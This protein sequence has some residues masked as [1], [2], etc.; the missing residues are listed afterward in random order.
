MSDIGDF[1]ANAKLDGE[2]LARIIET[3]GVGAIPIETVKKI[4]DR[5][6]NFNDKK[7]DG[8]RDELARKFVAGLKVEQ[9][10]AMAEVKGDGIIFLLVSKKI[11]ALRAQFIEPEVFGRLKPET[12]NLF[13]V[14]QIESLTAEQIGAMS[15]GQISDL[16]GFSEALVLNNKLQHLPRALLGK[17][18]VPSV[19]RA[20]S[21]GG[22]RKEA[23]A[24][25]LI[26]LAAVGNI[27]FLSPELIS[28]LD[29]STMEELGK[30]G[31]KT[32]YGQLT[33]DQ[34]DALAN[35]REDSFLWRGD[36]K[37]TSIENPN[38]LSAETLGKVDAATLASLSN[39]QFAIFDEEHLRVITLDQAR[40]LREDQIAA[41]SRANKLQ[42]LDSAVLEVLS[43]DSKIK[44][45]PEIQLKSL[46][47][48]DKLRMIPEAVANNRVRLFNEINDPK[49]L[50]AIAKTE[51]SH[52]GEDSLITTGPRE[53]K[54]A[55]T[56]LSEYLE[57]NW[58]TPIARDP[59]GVEAHIEGKL[60][61]MVVRNEDLSSD[62]IVNGLEFAQESEGSEKGLLD[63]LKKQIEASPEDVYGL[64]DKINMLRAKIVFEDDR[65]AKNDYLVF[66]ETVESLLQEAKNCDSV[67]K[68][69]SAMGTLLSLLGDESLDLGYRD[70]LS[71]R[72]VGLA[73][74]FKMFC[75][76]ARPNIGDMHQFAKEEL[77]KVYLSRAKMI[78]EVQSI[79]A[80]KIDRLLKGSMKIE[81]PGGMTIVDESALRSNL[82]T[83]TI[84]ETIYLK[85]ILSAMEINPEGVK[86]ISTLRFYFRKGIEII[87]T[88]ALTQSLAG[89]V[90]AS[91]GSTVAA[92]VSAGG[93]TLATN[94]YLNAAKLDEYMQ[95]SEA[96]RKALHLSEREQSREVER[97][98]FRRLVRGVKKLFNKFFGFLW[99]KGKESKETGS[100][101]SAYRLLRSEENVKVAVKRIR[102]YN[103]LS[104]RE[105][106][107]AKEDN[108]YLSTLG[109]FNGIAL[110]GSKND[111]KGSQGA[112]IGKLI[113]DLRSLKNEAVRQWLSKQII[114][115]KS[116][117]PQLE[118]NVNLEREKQASTPL[119]TT[120]YGIISTITRGSGQKI[121]PEKMR[122]VEKSLRAR[123]ISI[124]KL[125]S[126]EKEEF[127]EMVKKIQQEA[128]AYSLRVEERAAA[129]L[130]RAMGDE[131]LVKDVAEAKETH[132]KAHKKIKDSAAKFMPATSF[133]E[134]TVGTRKSINILP[135][136][137]PGKGTE[138]PDSPEPA[139]E[140]V[141]PADEAKNP[142]RHT[143]LSN[144]SQAND[145]LFDSLREG[146]ET[147]IP[148]L[149]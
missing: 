123:D 89:I 93:V 135:P 88:L 2:W 122:L 51:F 3:N 131:K 66:M 148:T 99:R 74:E 71:E 61:D 134:P 32:F 125:S 6:F 65:N 130:S 141:A 14:E 142:D 144:L 68:Y 84:G 1:P 67:D 87:T 146:T 95:A 103:V 69:V 91:V 30:D 119:V 109:M 124:E 16:I 94:K 7:Y 118:I 113:D 58:K 50:V 54:N 33:P 126:E 38:V 132:E 73:E 70:I 116:K 145:A 140:V 75:Y 37:I 17:L 34:L 77:C 29:D 112:R 143:L 49:L 147:E 115:L 55:G 104:S 5:V 64:G 110:S 20:A 24:N 59:A 139:R 44:V 72:L 63:S 100:S 57:G 105:Y 31:R 138:H 107:G 41:L 137:L 81:Q 127:L 106:L 11:C 80:D 8:A 90:R 18:D 128:T 85:N 117:F 136:P 25:Q 27:G 60:S 43:K 12:L 149:R 96:A 62:V 108:A 15:E 52:G 133:S 120:A 26:S 40:G 35:T 92:A 4:A 98:L 114:E 42:H 111:E 9:L 46:V 97:G 23:M 82:K 76:G 102:E 56:V 53:R 19:L 101:R 129:Q 28:G 22:K 79:D 121:S 13:T 10:E 83:L 36:R 45:L 21:G 86:G 78:A 48:S 47:V 39:D